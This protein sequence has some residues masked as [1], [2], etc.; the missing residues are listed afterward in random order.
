[1]PPG[2]DETAEQERAEEL[3]FL[4]FPAADQSAEGMEPSEEALDFPVTPTHGLQQLRSGPVLQPA[5]DF[6]RQSGKG[7]IPHFSVNS[8]QPIPRMNRPSSN[9]GADC[10]GGLSVVQ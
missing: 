2:D 5:V 1:M 3:D 9:L 7:S 4:M 6:Q 10:T 8:K